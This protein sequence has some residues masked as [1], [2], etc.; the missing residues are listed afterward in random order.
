MGAAEADALPEP[1]RRSNTRPQ[2]VKNNPSRIE[3]IQIR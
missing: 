3:D 1:R 2:T